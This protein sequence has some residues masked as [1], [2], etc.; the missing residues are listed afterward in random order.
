MRT[1]FLDLIGV[2]SEIKELRVSRRFDEADEACVL[3]F[4]GAEIEHCEFGQLLRLCNHFSTR[5][6]D[7]ITR[8]VKLDDVS[9]STRTENEIDTLVTDIIPRQLQSDYFLCELGPCD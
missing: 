5:L 7:Q 2:K 6:G 9:Q 3:N 8:K 4:V 1:C